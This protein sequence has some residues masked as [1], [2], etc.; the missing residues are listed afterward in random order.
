LIAAFKIKTR[1]G[2]SISP[3]DIQFSVEGKW[4]SFWGIPKR[5]IPKREWFVTGIGGRIEKA[6]ATFPRVDFISCVPGCA[7]VSFEVRCLTRPWTAI[8]PWGRLRLILDTPGPGDFSVRSRGFIRGWHWTI[9][10]DHRVEAK[11]GRYLA[12]PAEIRS[13]GPNS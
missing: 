4:D 8:R 3:A 10:L 6:R 7:T 5:T 11:F 13:S 12:G 9:P 1:N 2:F